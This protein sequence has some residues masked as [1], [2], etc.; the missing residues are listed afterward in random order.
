MNILLGS[1]Y[2]LGLNQLDSVADCSF[3]YLV[4]GIFFRFHK[5]FTILLVFFVPK[6]FWK[7]L[8]LKLLIQPPQSS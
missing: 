7:I 5:Y 3:F 8:F 4:F 2:Y 6:Y 1:G